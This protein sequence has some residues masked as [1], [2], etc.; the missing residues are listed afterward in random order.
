M[1]NI[2]YTLSLL[3]TFVVRES[4]GSGRGDDGAERG[5]D[6]Y[7]IHFGRF[8]LLGLE[9]PPQLVDHDGGEVVEPLADGVEHNQTQGNADHGVDHGEQFASVS[10]GS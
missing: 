1:Y 3:H 2:C 5:H 6:T 7:Q 8:L 9:Q 10:F 4:R